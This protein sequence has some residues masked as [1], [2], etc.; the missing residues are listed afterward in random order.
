LLKWIKPTDASWKTA[1]VAGWPTG[2]DVNLLA[3]RYVAPKAPTTA[4]PNPANPGTVLGPTVL[5]VTGSPTPNV[6]I[7]LQDGGL[8]PAKT[9]DGRLSQNGS[10]VALAM[11]SGGA[12]DLTLSFSSASGIFSGSFTH[13]LTHKKTPFKGA[14]LQKAAM[15][16]GYFLNVPVAGSP[17]SPSSGGVYVEKHED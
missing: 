13:P 4:A 7:V 1:Y 8:V 15:A 5:P 6:Q 12:A 10:L 16:G 14:A 2:I 9:N 3:S 17:D 11:P